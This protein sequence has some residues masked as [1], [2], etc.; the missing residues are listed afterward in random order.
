MLIAPSIA[1]KKAIT[2]LITPA[3]DLNRPERKV[4]TKGQY[5]EY[6]CHSSPGD[7]DSPVYSL[8]VPYFSTGSPEEWLL[9]MDNLNRPLSVRTSLVALVVMSSQNLFSK[10]MPLPLLG[11]KL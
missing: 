6:K 5:V 8:Q 4:L 7:P 11:T 3:I 9:F 1:K 10:G 2:S